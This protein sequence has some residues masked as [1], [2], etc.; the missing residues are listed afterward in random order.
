MATEII[1]AI[2]QRRSKPAK[3]EPAVAAMSVVEDDHADEL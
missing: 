1:S 3:A 2:T